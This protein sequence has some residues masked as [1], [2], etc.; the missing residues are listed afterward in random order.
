MAIDYGAM[1]ALNEAIKGT[2]EARRA[3]RQEEAQ[4]RNEMM[5]QEK[6]DFQNA[7]MIGQEQQALETSRENYL[8]QVQKIPHMRDYVNN[9]FDEKTAEFKGLIKSFNGRYSTAMGSGKVLDLKKSEKYQIGVQ[10][11][12]QLAQL[13][14][15]AA[16]ERT[17]D[18]ISR[19]D[20]LNKMKYLKGELDSFELSGLR[21][22]YDAIDAANYYEGERPDFNAIFSQQYSAV[23]HNWALENDD[24][25]QAKLTALAEN[26][27]PGDPNGK[28][29][30]L[31][32]FAQEDMGMKGAYDERM[33]GTKELPPVEA[34]SR[35]RNIFN[36]TATG[37]NAAAGMLANAAS[38]PMMQQFGVRAGGPEQKGNMQI[39][40]Y[41]IF[42]SAPD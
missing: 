16:D 25:N 39:A 26:Y 37:P 28:E 30:V 15:Y 8:K 11:A 23:V 24:A 13:D 17:A 42:N 19:R 35:V 7:Q 4:M 38:Q 27:Y 32:Q 18:K 41:E 20:Q 3:R 34:T 31:K 22:E 33:V 5:Q 14:A 12:N 1:M 10:S 21:A 36:Q 29:K 40:G 2:S 6:L 9:Y